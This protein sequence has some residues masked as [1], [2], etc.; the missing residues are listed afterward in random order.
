MLALTAMPATAAGTR[1]VHIVGGKVAVSDIKTR[2]DAADFMVNMNIALDQLHLP[3]NRRIVLTPMLVG[4]NDSTLLRPIVINDARQQIM[5]NRRDHRRYDAQNAYV[6][7]RRNGKQQSLAYADTTPYAEWMRQATVKISEDLCGC[8]DLQNQTSETLKRMYTPQCAYISPV[9]AETKTYQMHGRAYIDFPV[10]RTELHPDYRNNPRELQKIVDTINI[11]R[12]DTLVT[13]TN[14]DIHGYASPES[15]YKHNA[16]LAENRAA[17]L[18]NYVRQLVKMDDRLF[19]VHY[20]PEDWDGLRRHL[21]QS[22]IDNKEA[23]LAIANDES[24]EPDRREWLIKSQYPDQYRTMLATWYPALRH[25]DY[26]ITCSVRPFTVDEAKRL[27]K[28][29]PQLLS[30]NEMYRV[31][32]TY[33]PGSPEFNEVM[34][35]AVRM[36][37]DDPTANLNAACSRLAEGRYDMAKGYL[38]KAGDTPEADNARGIYYFN[39][40]NEQEAMTYFQRAADKGCSVAKQNIE[41]M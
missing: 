33:E 20:T 14:I 36:F 13:I 1:T 15:P 25:S 17:T 37:P 39:T 41:N 26:I 8:G 6:I 40:G 21:R 2:K 11:V 10:D 24:I 4:K 28:T 12:N 29:R 23:I 31:A 5:Y 38:D 27:I 3:T 18:K 34:E 30:Q 19:S 35:T 22:N 9:A 32:Q 7:R 16:W